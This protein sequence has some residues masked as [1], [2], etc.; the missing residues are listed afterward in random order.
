MTNW[1]N[2]LDLAD[3]SAT[4]LQE[5]LDLAQ[6]YQAGKKAPALKRPVYGVNLFFENSTRTKSSFQM[7]EKKLGI[8][9]IEVNPATSSVQ[10]G[11]TLS[12]TLRTL[13][14][15]GVDFAV[16]RHGQ[17]GW[18]EEL[19]ENPY[20]TL[21][22]FN[23]GD[24][25]GVHPS[26]TLLDLLTIENEFGRIDGLKVGIIGDLAHS[27]VAKSDAKILKSLG[28]TLYF[29]GPESWYSRDFDDL[30]TFGTLAEILP[31]LD[32]VMM[33]RVQLER[34]DEANRDAFTAVDYYQQFGLTQKRAKLLP[35]QSIIMHPAP[36][37]R[38]VE[39]ASELV[40]GDKSRIFTQM[41]NGVFARMAMM[42][43]V[44][45]ARGLMEVDKW[46]Y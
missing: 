6:D 29:G 21:G 30:G 25:A 5:V 37:N 11:E 42:T 36:V 38:N 23:A 34:F 40:D 20:V 28:A 43:K 44:L 27:R 46:E 35:K 14:A 2:C 10:K 3:L 15:I 41:G 24:G 12:D 31:E 45:Q 39:I 33:L 8:D 18:Y 16:I 1:N 26:Q 22:L 17:T 4:Q 32:V 13:E 7:A 9:L 19:M